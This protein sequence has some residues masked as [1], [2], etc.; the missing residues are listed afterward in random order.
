MG[1][2]AKPRDA[3][4]K[5]RLQQPL[6]RQS[7]KSTMTGKPLY[8]FLRYGGLAYQIYDCV[9]TMGYWSAKVC[10]VPP[11]QSHLHPC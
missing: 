2:S 7:S 5:S 3:M 4:S 9:A 10:P 8:V 6:V 1:A 11:K